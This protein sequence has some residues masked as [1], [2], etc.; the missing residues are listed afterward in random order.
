LLHERRGIPLMMELPP[1]TEEQIWKWAQAYNR[2]TGSWPSAYSPRFPP[3]LP[4][5]W[6]TIE[7]CLREGRRGLKGGSSLTQFLAKKGEVAFWK[8]KRMP[9]RLQ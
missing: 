5:E 4:L 8:N 9:A 2:H 6:I 7:A 3:S 1:L